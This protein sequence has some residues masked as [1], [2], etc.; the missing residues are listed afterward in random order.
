ML[1]L[2]Y[3]ERNQAIDYLK[4]NYFQREETTHSSH[5]EKQASLVLK[6]QSKKKKSNFYNHVSTIS[7]FRSSSTELMDLSALFL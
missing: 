1:N 6:S 5:L 2:N 7:A 3:D 4:T